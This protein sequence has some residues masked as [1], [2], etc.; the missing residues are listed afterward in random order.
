MYVHQLSQFTVN[1]S[2][3]KEYSNQYYSITV[4][5]DKIIHKIRM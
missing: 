4:L 3:T 2:M 5:L 1:M